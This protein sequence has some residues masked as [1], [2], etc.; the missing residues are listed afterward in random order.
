[1]PPEIKTAPGSAGQTPVPPATP[2]TAEPPA[3]T[4]PAAPPGEGAKAA[5]LLKRIGEPK[6]TQTPA[7]EG[8]IKYNSSDIEKIQDPVARKVVED[9]YRDMNA[10]LQ[11]K[12]QQIAEEKRKL[13]EERRGLDTWTPER[14]LRESQNPSFIESS[15]QLIQARAPQTWSGTQEEWSALN[16]HEKARFAQ[17]ETQLDTLLAQQDKMLVEQADREIRTKFPDYNPEL[18]ETF[19]KDLLANRINQ[20]EIRELIWKAKNFDRYMERTYEFGRQDGNGNLKEK[21]NATTNPT[22]SSVRTTDEKPVREE[23]ESPTSFFRR[24][25]QFNLAREK[26][27][28]MNETTASQLQ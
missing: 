11:R 10:G 8:E 26:S 2:K 12:F 23:N 16:D 6:Q 20:Q 27:R 3:Q 13:D 15:K 24:L 5:D 14:V 17:L 19:Q 28:R 18:V 7:P 25:A 22:G 9:I 21:L 1:M 4:P